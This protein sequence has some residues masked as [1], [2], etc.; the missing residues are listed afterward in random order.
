MK[1][2]YPAVIGKKA[3]GGYEASFPDLEGCYAQG[4]TLEEAVDNANEAAYNWIY[5][6]VMEE[7]DGQLPPVSDLSD[8][9]LEEGEE[10]RNI[11]VNI[12]FR[13]GWDE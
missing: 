5:V 7:E 1:F 3:E 4:D 2:I 8:I 13:D 6:E 10:V 11:A 9:S 12:R